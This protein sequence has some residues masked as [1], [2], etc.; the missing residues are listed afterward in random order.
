M[1]WLGI[2]NLDIFM[3]KANFSLN[4]CQLL[5]YKSK[6]SSYHDKICRSFLKDG[7]L[8]RFGFRFWISDFF[9]QMANNSNR[10]ENLLFS[11]EMPTLEIIAD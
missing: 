4:T 5:A 9:L 2:Y 7:I 6:I 11:R 3:V 1:F 10:I 8:I